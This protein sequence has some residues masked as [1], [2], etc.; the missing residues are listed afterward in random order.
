MKDRG[1]GGKLE[2]VERGETVIGAYCVREESIF[3]KILKQT[4]KQTKSS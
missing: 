3:I 4:N 2:G 1:G